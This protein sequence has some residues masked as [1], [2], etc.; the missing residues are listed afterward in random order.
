[1]GIFSMTPDLQLDPALKVWVLLPL[2]VIMVCMTQ[3][4]SYLAEIMQSFPITASRPQHRELAYYKYAQYLR[5]NAF[6]LSNMER[7]KR[8]RTIIPQMREGSYLAD[9]NEKPPSPIPNLL[10]PRSSEAMISGMRNQ[11]LNYVPQTLIMQWV[12]GFFG[13]V[14]VMK[15]PFPL[16]N[17]F[18]TMLQSNIGTLDLDV[19]YVS[20]IS[21][22]FILTVGLPGILLLLSSDTEYHGIKVQG[23][24][25]PL[26]ASTYKRKLLENEADALELTTSDHVLDNALDR[27]LNA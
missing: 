4:K 18:K 3:I 11:I 5:L 8:T 12:N 27:L 21:W 24:T 7:S 6:N 23:A 14:I 17:R 16:T 20:S 13:A 10:D 1:M 26:P 9:P 15:L 2:L 25:E 22:F 19:R